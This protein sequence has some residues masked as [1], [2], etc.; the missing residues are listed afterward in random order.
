MTVRKLVLVVASMCALSA[1]AAAPRDPPAS[2]GRYLIEM[3]GCG[4]C[5]TPGH[6]LGKEDLTRE[7]AGGDVGFEVPG[8]GTF[9]GPNLTPDRETGLGGWTDQQVERAIRNGV[10]PDGRMLSPVMPWA[11]FTIMS[12]ADLAAIIA[13]LRTLRPVSRKVPGPFAPGTVPE[14]AAW[15]M[16]VPPPQSGPKPDMNLV[17]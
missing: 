2:R 10:R 16:Y 3:A 8:A 1:V 9:I 11:N 14:V 7:L 13:Y 17:K 6:F 15:R 12:D 5:H 4:H